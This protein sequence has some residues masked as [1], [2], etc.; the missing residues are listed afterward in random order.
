VTRRAK[1]IWLYPGSL[2]Q[3]NA[4]VRE[5]HR[6]S[7]PVRGYKFSLLAWSGE[8]LLGVAIVGRTTA[9][10]LHNDLTAEVTRVCTT[11]SANVCSFLYGACWRVWREMGGKRIITYTLQSESGASLRAAGF[12]PV[13]NAK[14]H[15]W[16][17][18]SRPR[19]SQPVYSEDKIRWE[20]P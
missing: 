9:R 8:G 15:E 19:G 1:E 10:R 14:A 16:S 7:N 2:K 5:H 20:K 4:F 12:R 17:R 6:H 18:E 13:A 3:A 11:G